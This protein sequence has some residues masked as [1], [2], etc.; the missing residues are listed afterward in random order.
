MLSN[1]RQPEDMAGDLHAQIASGQVGDQR[2]QML[3]DSRGLDDIQDLADEIIR[4]SEEATRRS[5]RDLPAGTYKAHSVLDLADGSALDIHVAITV[6]PLA[7]EILVDYEA[8]SG[9]GPAGITVVKNYT[10][11]YP[12]FTI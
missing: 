9:A 11:P 3:C 6:D 8:S 4:R 5:I 12:T 7:G 1:V 2:L 10:P